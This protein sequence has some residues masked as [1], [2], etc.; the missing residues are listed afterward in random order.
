MFA[1]SKVALVYCR[2]GKLAQAEPILLEN[3]QESIALRGSGHSDTLFCKCRL[4]RL[5]V[6]QGKFELG[7][8]VLE[9]VLKASKT[10][11]GED[12][13]WTIECM[14]YLAC[15][16]RDAGQL[17]LALPLFQQTVAKS[18]ERLGPEHQTT[19]VIMSELARAYLA[20]QTPEKAIP[21]FEQTLAK[22]KEH[23]G[24]DDP[25]TR[26]STQWLAEAYRIAGKLDLALPL[27][28]QILDGHSKHPDA[29]SPQ[30]TA[31]LN[32]VC[33][34]LL[35]HERHSEA[36][37]LLRACLAIR[38]KQEPD[39][40]TTFETKSL[41]GTALLGQKKYADAQPLLLTGYDGM[42]QREA[43]IPAESKVRL[44][45]ALNWLIELYIST[46]KPDEVAKWQAERAKYP[47]S[48][49]PQESK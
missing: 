48:A 49:P 1:K 45:E 13:P 40:W 29:N 31:S 14:G 39:A 36:E 26:Y 2:Q 12:H 10:S 34:D 16:Y 18:Q 47:Q 19:L 23:F 15:G 27:L 3:L 42:K 22:Q 44:P 25:P 9:E 37:K 6:S 21:L 41:L 20:S 38:E 11:R 17:D 7:L 46:D 33:R 28:K 32:E 5:H 24:I 43:K 30:F 8:P 4:A 35:K